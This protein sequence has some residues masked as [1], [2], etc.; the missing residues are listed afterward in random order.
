MAIINL[1]NVY[2][3]INNIKRNIFY[4]DGITLRFMSR[5]TL[6]LELE[7]GWFMQTAPTSSIA[8]KAFSSGS[9]KEE[10]FECSVALDDESIDLENII[11]LS[12]EVVINNE[13]FKISGYVKP[14]IATKKWNL[15]LT[16]V[17]QG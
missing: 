8:D 13:K 7:S 9:G 3:N 15:R 5:N 1:T 6:L 17:G 4:D 11:K 12:T 16:T 10:F 14:R 2:E